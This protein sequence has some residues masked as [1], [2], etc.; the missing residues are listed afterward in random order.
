[1]TLLFRLCFNAL[2]LILIAEYIP[3]IAVDGLY[4][5]LMSALMLGI[6]NVFIRPILLVLTFPI[7][8]ITLGLFT[9][10]INALLF[11]FAASF[12]EGFSVD[13]FG[14]ALF[15]SL[16]MTLV[17]TIGN[18]WINSSKVVKQKVEYREIK[19]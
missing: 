19:D 5:A 3:G 9:F 10:V 13:G 12:I 18:R 1:M 14:Y 16:F 15:G 8:I 17:S 2:G 11:M 4:P 6:L 7:T